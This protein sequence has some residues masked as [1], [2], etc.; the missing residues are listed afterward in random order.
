MAS[1]RHIDVKGMRELQRDLRKI[2]DKSLM[3]ELRAAH[4][5]ASDRAAK[6]AALE[7]PFRSGKLSRSIKA[8][9]TNKEGRIKIGTPKRTPYAGPIHFGWLKHGIKKNEFGYR[10]IRNVIKEIQKDYERDI[11]N[12]AA[13]IGKR[14]TKR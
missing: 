10:G 12:V 5:K 11:N 6:A 13:K 3:N 14:F 1:S 9:P 7:A 4:K 8:K 2:G